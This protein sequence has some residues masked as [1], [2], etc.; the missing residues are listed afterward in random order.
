MS[1]YRGEVLTTV[2]V[3]SDIHGMLLPLQRVLAEPAVAAADRVVV[4]G[5]HLWGPQP[6]EVLDTLLALGERAVLVR[7]N[8]DREILQMSRGVD[9][10]L[11]DDPVSVWGAAQLSVAHAAVIASLPTSVT[12]DVDGFGPTVFCHATPRDDEEVVIVDSRLERWA[13][14][15]GGL[16]PSVTTVVC[17]HTHTPYVR[18]AAG[19]L[20]VNPGSVG[21]PYGRPGA[22]WGLL[23]DGGVS[24][25]R[26][27]LDVDDLISRTAAA[28]SMPGVTAWLEDYVRSPASDAEVLA[29]FRPREP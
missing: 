23:A 10:G 27:L 6:T 20:V 22:H 15:F 7:G 26:T 24:L 2:A 8:A 3:L 14:V 13:E 12:L 19:R 28:S 1:G 9:V 11:N 4:T 16:H 25:R 5:D 18:L 21:L 17:G 29:A